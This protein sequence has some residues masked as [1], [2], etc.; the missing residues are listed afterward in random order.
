[1]F[2]SQCCYDL[3]EVSLS[4]VVVYMILLYILYPYTA[5]Y[6]L[7]AQCVHQTSFLFTA[8][9]TRIHFSVNSR[10]EC[11]Y[12]HSLLSSFHVFSLQIVD[13]VSYGI[14]GTSLSDF[15]GLIEIFKFILKDFHCD[16]VKFF[17]KVFPA[18]ETNLSS[19]WIPEHLGQ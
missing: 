18:W 10:S 17:C 16:F 12:V 1:M 11:I 4:P 14:N 6:P 13:I 3:S 7:Q 9:L 15:S 19:G 5:A 2:L 8:C